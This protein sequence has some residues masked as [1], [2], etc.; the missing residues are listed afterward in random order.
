MTLGVPGWDTY[1]EREVAGVVFHFD[2]RVR[3]EVYVGWVVIYC[4]E[5]G[6]RVYICDVACL[7]CLL[8]CD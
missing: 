5:E 3:T 7:C 8:H 2:D 4:G 6:V 1:I